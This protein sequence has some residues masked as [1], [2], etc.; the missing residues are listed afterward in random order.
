MNTTVPQNDDLWLICGKKSAREGILWVF[1]DRKQCI[2]RLFPQM[3]SK[4][5]MV[6]KNIVFFVDMCI[7]GYLWNENCRTR[8][9]IRLGK[10]KGSVHLE[11]VYAY[12]YM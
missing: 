3:S 1:V 11:D 9:S 12:I 6:K 7:G 10:E 2:L 5:S 8:H 4:S